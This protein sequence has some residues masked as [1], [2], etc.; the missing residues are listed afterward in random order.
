MV[1]SATPIG[2]YDKRVVLL[3][4]ERG[5][6]TAFARGARRPGNHLMAPASPFAFGEFSVFKGKNS[7]S[8]SKAD[9]KEYFRDL[10]LDYEKTCFG[11][12]FLEVCEYFG[13][14][15]QDET[16]LIT[17]LYITLKAIEKNVVDRW[18]IKAIFEFKCLYLNGTYPDVFKCA[19]CGRAEN[20]ILLSTVDSCVYCAD[21]AKKSDNLGVFLSPACMYALRFIIE[22][23]ANRLFS[24][25]LEENARAELVRT[26]GNFFDRYIE[27][28]FNSEEFLFS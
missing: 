14:E 1:L 2:E 13:L 24:F 9:I 6:I 10:S 12:Y 19:S 22:A 17:L 28:K 8:L 16:N 21:C 11:F 20:L 7:Y 26:V 15:G 23:P 3:T 4:R 27:H 25:E 18:L 5:K